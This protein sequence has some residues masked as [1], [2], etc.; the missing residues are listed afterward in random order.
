MALRSATKFLM[1]GMNPVK[2]VMLAAA[3]LIHSTADLRSCECQGPKLR[4]YSENKSLQA[5][6]CFDA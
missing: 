3:S 6:C 5:R 2:V 1:S 4:T